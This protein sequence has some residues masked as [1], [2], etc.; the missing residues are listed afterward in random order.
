MKKQF[1]LG[2]IG[3]FLG[4]ATALFVILSASSNEM[5]LSGVQAA[6]FSS[7]GLMGAAIAKKET[8]FAG[9]MLI[10]SAVFITLTVPIA[11]TLSFLYLYLPTVIC[12]GVAG[13]LCFMEPDARSRE[14]GDL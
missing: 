5:I 13:T 7:L 2:I 11:N 3:G 14:S 6:L 4:L 1:I 10:T 9:Y 12:L 8:K